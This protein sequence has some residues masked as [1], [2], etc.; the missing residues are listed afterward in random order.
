MESLALLMGRCPASKDII[1]GDIFPLQFSFGE[2]YDNLVA[3]E[4]EELEEPSTKGGRHEDHES[5]SGSSDLFGPCRMRF[6]R[7][8]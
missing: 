8:R 7:R 5:D 3:I 6:G 4:K 1:Q 2:E